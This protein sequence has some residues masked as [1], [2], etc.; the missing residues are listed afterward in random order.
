MI[1]QTSFK[2]SKLKIEIL[3]AKNG[4]TNASIDG[5]FLHSNY[6]PSKEAE[7]FV[8]N[9]KIPNN[10][11]I[12]IIT[13]P[14][15]DYLTSYLRIKFPHIKIGAIRYV[16]GFENYNSNFDF[17]INYYEFN[18]IIG[19]ENYLFDLL[20]EEKIM[21]TYFLKW[22]ASSRVLSD[23]DS[24]VWIAIKNIYNK[25][26]TLLITRQYFEKKWLLNTFNFI[27]NI[28]NPITIKK[29]NNDFPIFIISSGPSLKNYLTFIKENQNNAFVICLSSAISICLKYSIKIDLC[30]STDGGYWAG[31]HL[32]K[33]LNYKIPIALSPES[34][35]LKKLLANPI[36]ILKY[37]DGLSLEILNKS[38]LDTFP[39]ERNGTISG[40]A[41]TFALR[42]SNSDIFFFGLDLSSQKG[43]QHSQPNELEANSSCFYNRINNSEKKQIISEYSNSSLQVYK[44][45]F[46]NFKT[47]NH[48]VYRV[49]DSEFK[50]NS[51][52]Q[53][54]D[55]N[56]TELKKIFGFSRRE[57]DKNIFDISSTNFK[58]NTLSD[59][60]TNDFNT[61][62]VKR[63]LY[64][65]DYIQYL[66]ENNSEILDRIN[67]KHKQLEI[68]L[69]HIIN[70]SL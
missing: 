9:L 8:D 62:R 26:K 38:G 51:L 37:N 42:L 2:A 19:F 69:R 60:I 47:N 29:T 20:N 46:E 21:L 50:K 27:Q 39:A 12:I 63:Q 30:I 4:E 1:S 17:I 41:L 59:F 58:K 33:L 14:G 64:P 53:I 61:E 25:A 55:I 66:H 10:P 7:R 3:N 15:L 23:I 44:N 49:I 28:S 16:K 11:S 13:E 31:Q 18:S 43:Y 45:W 65:M 57:I 40:T 34:Y 54:K 24:K 22:E 48:K 67:S 35:C 70:E 5:V 56:I 6:N 36:L 68:K 32:K 52:G